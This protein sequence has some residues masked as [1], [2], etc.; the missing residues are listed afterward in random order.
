MRQGAEQLANV[1][2]QNR[3]RIMSEHIKTTFSHRNICTSFVSKQAIEIYVETEQ[4]SKI[5]DKNRVHNLK[6]SEWIL[7]LRSRAHTVLIYF[8]SFGW[9][10]RKLHLSP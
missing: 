9:N 2:Q 5:N 3:N 7:G 10:D 4:R 6:T 1:D 8:N